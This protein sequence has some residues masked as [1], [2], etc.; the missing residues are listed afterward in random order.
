MR[1]VHAERRISQSLAGGMVA[2]ALCAVLESVWARSAAG[3]DRP[4]FGVTFLSCWG[5]FAPM[6]AVI[7]V[8]VGMLVTWLEPQEPPSVG[9]WVARLRRFA[10]GR[11]ADV[12]AFAPLAVVGAFLWSTGMAH[13][14]RGIL[15]LAIAPRMAGLAMMGSALG[16]GLIL[17]IVTLALV[18]PLRR[19]L[20]LLAANR[21]A[22]VDPA[23]TGGTALVAVL[24]LFLIGLSRGSVSGEGGFLGVFGI[25]KR[26]ELDLRGVAELLFVAITAAFA[27]NVGRPRKGRGL[28]VT[29]V[30]GILA[31]S[32]VGLVLQS[33]RTL[34]N[35]PGLAQAIERGAPLS[36][37]TL[38]SW[39]KLADKDRDGVSGAF[40]GGDCDDNNAA[41]NPL[42][43]EILDNGIDEDC[44]G[45]DLTRRTVDALAPTVGITKIDRKL[46]PD[47]LNVVLITID[48]LRSDLG[49]TGY[50]RPISP[51][52]DALAARSVV[53]DNAYSLAS[54]TGKSVGPMLIGKYGSET[55]RNWGHFNKFNESDTFLAQRLQ[56]EGVRTLGAH[57]HRYF[58]EFG[59][60]NR[61]FDV[62][63]F[64]AAPPK[65]AP[66]D[67][68]TKATAEELTNAAIGLLGKPENTDK[69][70]FM[71]VHYLDPHADYLKHEGID[72]GT[73]PRDLYDAEVAYTDKY[74]GLL[75][76]TIEQASWG[77]R[78]VVILTSD[79]GEAFGEHDMWR[80]GFEVWEVL[81]RVPLIVSI[82]GQKPKHVV[83]RRSLI[84]LVPTVLELMHIRAPERREDNRES[85]DFLSGN[86]LLADIYE[87]AGTPPPAVR[88][89]FVDMPAGP[90]NDARRALIHDDQK[91]IV[92][93]EARFDLYDLAA[94]P[95]EGRNLAKTSTEKLTEMKER[96]AAM[97]A[98]LREV[99]VTGPR[100]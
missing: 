50:K 38:P 65:D 68:D 74:I 89:V 15:A 25:F 83:P 33:A 63:D 27:Q 26:P 7:A 62:I 54:Y 78:T 93:N 92:S 87:R 98:W 85:T 22:F 79:H 72:F 35:V 24:G 82:P 90:Y 11:Q 52:I 76:S 4:A 57:A 42:A 3:D 43:E 39:R 2:S 95:L 40:G 32:P 88:D 41:I 5:L 77:K 67:I 19:G 64:A 75:L 99:K 36:K 94:D 18:P 81:V 48:T 10:V 46:V 37:T 84:D 34:E 97:K 100:K 49:F 60:L 96:Y 44:S 58:D 47:D 16:L 6:C 8:M 55:N 66:W 17:A 1:S 12:A 73:A 61:G 45:A 70:F 56:R 29:V 20:A 30:V 13:I 21:P 51:N 80:H 28:P 14:A 31:V 86:S 69:R 9:G 59:G 91:L 53:F 71:W 23:M